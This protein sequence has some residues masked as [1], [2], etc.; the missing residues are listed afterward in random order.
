M[1]QEKIAQIF[2]GVALPNMMSLSTINVADFYAYHGIIFRLTGNT[3]GA[4]KISIVT[5]AY[6]AICRVALSS[7]VFDG[8]VSMSL[9]EAGSAVTGGGTATPKN[10]ERN[11][12]YTNLVTCKTG[13]TYANDGTLLDTGSFKSPLPNLWY[14]K[15]STQY[16]ITFDGSTNYSIQWAEVPA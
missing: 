11:G 13:V 5:P 2:T 4:Q 6:T 14:L 10:A 3:G 12:T 8:G 16:V 1:L 9:Y 7:I 15:A